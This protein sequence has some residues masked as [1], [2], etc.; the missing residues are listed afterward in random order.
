ME[1][2]FFSLNNFKEGKKNGLEYV[3]DKSGRIIKIRQ[4]NNDYK[5]GYIYCYANNDKLKQ[6]AYFIND[7]IN[8][9]YFE[10]DTV[11]GSIV[12]YRELVNYNGTN[13]DNQI[14]HF[15]DGQI[16]WE[17]SFFMKVKAVGEKNYELRIFGK[18]DFPFLTAFFKETD[19]ING[20]LKTTNA[21]FEIV[22]KDNRSILYEVKKIDAKY[23]IGCLLNYRYPTD[24]EIL[25]KGINRLQKIGPLM[26]FKI[27]LKN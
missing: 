2:N 21:D 7:T 24:D 19:N 8:G 26:Y 13:I 1:G 14:I 22:S 9:N 16:D 5:N 6:L 18:I 11:S 17:S 4:W 3:V 27:K 23:A 15:K 20:L 25:G 12:E 10:L